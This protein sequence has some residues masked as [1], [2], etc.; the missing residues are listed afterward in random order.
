MTDAPCSDF[1]DTQYTVVL[2]HFGRHAIPYMVDVHI[3]G[4]EMSRIVPYGP[5]ADLDACKN[6]RLVDNLQILAGVERM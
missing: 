3:E 6:L 4:L 5:L 1:F 2:L